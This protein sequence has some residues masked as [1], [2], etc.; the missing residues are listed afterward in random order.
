MKIGGNFT[1]IPVVDKTIHQSIF[2]GKEPDDNKLTETRLFE[3][4]AKS[5]EERNQVQSY[6]NSRICSV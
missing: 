1:K 4:K 5:D 3:C 6:I 2:G